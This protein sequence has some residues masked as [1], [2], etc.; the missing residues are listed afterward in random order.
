MEKIT[1]DPFFV[2][3][4]AVRTSN[5]PGKAAIDIPELW[6][7]FSTENIASKL[8]NK[9]GDEVYSVYTDYEGDYTQ[10]YTTLIGYAV[11]NLD[12]IPVGMRGVTI[13]A[14]PYQKH[15]LKGNMNEGL[16]F[17]GWLAIWKSGVSRAYTTDFE[18]YGGKAQQPEIAEVD[19]FIALR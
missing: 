8:E 1:L 5:A 6:M 2:V 16:V 18:V 19:I 4:I 15:V 12:Q 14:G 3:G 7:R 13:A 10:P 9:V 17:N 11:R